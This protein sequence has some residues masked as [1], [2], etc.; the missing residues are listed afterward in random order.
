MDKPLNESVAENAKYLELDEEFIRLGQ[1]LDGMRHD[2]TVPPALAG[3]ALQYGAKKE[4]DGRWFYIGAVPNELLCFIDKRRRQPE[5]SFLPE[6][7]KYCPHCG[8]EM[9]IRRRR[10]NRSFQGLL[11]TN[12]GNPEFWGCTS[13]PACTKT[14]PIKKSD[15]EMRE[16]QKVEV[17]RQAIAE[18][19]KYALSVLGSPSAVD[20]WMFTPMIAFGRRKPVDFLFSEKGRSRIRSLLESIYF[21]TR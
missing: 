15:T 13:Y 21:S 19:S 5:V 9:V 4:R 1:V 2:L 20:R 18:L 17:D 14:L 12:S 7:V 16:V 3:Y 11:Q 6:D 8:S 10:E